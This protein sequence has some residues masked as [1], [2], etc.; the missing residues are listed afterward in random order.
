MFENEQSN[1]EINLNLKMPP[2]QPDGDFS[3]KNLVL[4]IYSAKKTFIVWCCIGLALGIIAAAGYLIMNTFIS[5]PEE[6]GDVK[7]TLTLN[8]SGAEQA[9]LPNGVEFDARFFY[10]E[11]SLWEN[12]IKAAGNSEVTVGDLISRLRSLN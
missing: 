3:M 7:V 5:P 4:T 2:E 9:L 6:Q 1:S 10:E 8:Y 12:A 11:I